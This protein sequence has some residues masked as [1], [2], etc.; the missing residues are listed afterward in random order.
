[1]NAADT[2]SDAGQYDIPAGCDEFRPL[3]GDLSPYEE[4]PG[5]F[6]VASLAH[7]SHC[8]DHGFR[9]RQPA[10]PHLQTGT[11]RNQRCASYSLEDSIF[12]LKIQDSIL[13]CIFEIL[14]KSILAKMKIFFE[15]TFHK[16]P[17]V[18]CVR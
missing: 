12:I 13:S 7:D 8:L 15:D 2:D 4:S 18:H 16:I 1:M 14:L 9:L 3:S 17:F 6:T 5:S 10:V 11:H